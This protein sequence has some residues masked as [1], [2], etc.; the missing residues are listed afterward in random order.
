MSH[1][2]VYDFS[3]PANHAMSGNLCLLASDRNLADPLRGELIIK[4]PQGGLADED[5]AGTGREMGQEEVLIE[6][7]QAR[8]GVHRIA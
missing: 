7:L 3:F 5:A 8:G 2:S 4:L 6:A 1:M